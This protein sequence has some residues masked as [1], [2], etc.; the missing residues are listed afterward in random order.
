MTKDEVYEQLNKIFQEVLELDEVHLTDS[1]T[2]DDIEE[3]DSLAHIGL[4]SAVERLFDI[5]FSMKE[6]VNMHNVGEMVELILLKR[7]I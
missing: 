6:I 7:N 4:I 3:W 2:A 5:K 1:T